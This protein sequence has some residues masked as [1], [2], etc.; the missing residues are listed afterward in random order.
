MKLAVNDKQFMKDMANLVNYGMGYIEGVK[1]GVTDMLSSIAPEIK[2]MLEE[3]IDASARVNPSALHHVYEWH[4]AGDSVARLFDIDY[5]V[6]G[7]GLSM[8]STFRQSQSI[9]DRANRPFYNKAAVM[10]S[11]ASLNIK[12][13]GSAN[14]GSDTLM[15]D[16]DGETIFAKEVFVP[17]AG[18]PDVAGS[19][20][21]TFREF[22]L[23]YLSQT[24]LDV[25]GL[26]QHFNTP[27]AFKNNVAA[28]V[29][30]GRPIG[31][32]VGREWMRM[33]RKGEI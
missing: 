18:G 23:R 26:R 1:M 5:K 28:G 27:V 2:Y 31:V 25:T 4:S 14:G 6:T 33:K 10:E 19:Y 20:E 11:G 12:P 24:F 3:Y 21:A 15:F 29:K 30:G 13:R 22:F 8:Q 32:R 7:F 17:K 16:I 9:S